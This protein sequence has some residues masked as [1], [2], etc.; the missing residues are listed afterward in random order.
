MRSQFEEAWQLPSLLNHTCLSHWWIT[1]HLFWC[2]IPQDNALTDVSKLLHGGN[3]PCMLTSL[4]EVLLIDYCLQ[5]KQQSECWLTKML[6]IATSL[7][8]FSSKDRDGGFTV[9][10]FQELTGI[11]GGAMPDKCIGLFLFNDFSVSIVNHWAKALTLCWRCKNRRAG[12]MVLLFVLNRH[13]T[14]TLRE[15]PIP[16]NLSLNLVM[17]LS[18]F[19][20][21]KKRFQLLHFKFRYACSCSLGPETAK[22]KIL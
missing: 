9:T 15:L 8:V 22:A 4:L 5:T 20:R 7:E 16:F 17:L 12:P 6:L 14:V 11:A 21:W 10:P 19:S 2:D 3:A 13:Q 1:K 18:V